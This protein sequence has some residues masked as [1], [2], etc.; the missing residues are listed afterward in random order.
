MNAALF[1]LF[2]KARVTGLAGFQGIDQLLLVGND[3]PP[4]I[5]GHQRPHQGADVDEGTPP[6]EEF[7]QTKSEPDQENKPDYRKGCGVFPQGRSA[8]QIVDDPSTE[9]YAQTDRNT[10]ARWDGGDA[11]VQ[12]VGVGSVI[13]DNTQQEESADPRKIGLPLEPVQHGGHLRRHHHELIDLVESAGVNHPKFTF[14]V[15]SIVGYLLQVAIEPHEEK[16][17][18]DPGDA[19]DDVQPADGEVQPLVYDGVH[20]GSH[21]SEGLRVGQTSTHQGIGRLTQPKVSCIDEGL[22]LSCPTNRVKPSWT[23]RVFTLAP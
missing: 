3:D 4:N 9:K 10:G 16:G 15:A 11:G 17:A 19:C 14:N 7:T 1:G 22:L 18:A 2:A 8:E 21:H 23:G 5:A 13:V 20:E 12:Q 6:A